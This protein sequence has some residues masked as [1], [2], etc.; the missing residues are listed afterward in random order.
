MQLFGRRE[1]FT[2][3]E[4]ITPYNVLEV[5]EKTIP[6]HNKNRKQIQYLYNYYTG[7]QPVLYREKEIRPEINNKIVENRANEIVSFK[8][9]YLMGEPI[10]YVNRSGD[11][12]TV[13]SIKRL[14][15]FVFAEDKPTKDKELADWLH[16]CGLAYRM[17]L[18]NDRNEED[19]S[20]FKI[21]T[22]S[23]M[24]TFVVRY[25]GLGNK[26]VMGVKYVVKNNRTVV[27]SVYTDD[28]YFEIENRN[29]I[30]DIA[31]NPLGRI[32]IIEYQ[33]NT[34]RLGAFE[35]VIPLLD[36][37]NETASNRLDG[38]EQFIQA[39]LMLKGVDI[40][41]ADFK[42]LKD[43][44][45][46]KIPLDGDIK[47]LVQELDQSQVQTYVNYMYDA[48]LTICGMPNRNGGSSTS[49][50]GKAVIM[51][52]GWSSAEARAK[53]TESMFK[54][55]EKDFLRLALMI[56]DAYRDLNLKL[57]QIDI[58]FTRRNYENIVEKSQVLTTM[59]SNDKIH[60]RLAFEHC[61]MF[62]DP[63]TAYLASKEY[64]KE[65]EAETQ[66]KLDDSFETQIDDKKK[67]LT[68]DGEED[69]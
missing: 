32:P 56:S 53:D 10:Q 44:G 54:K 5:L 3:V 20:P 40:E 49:D 15:E 17:A 68:A 51:R 43:L 60:P 16:I 19:E 22:L 50:T 13:H 27:Y 59:L 24:N 48:V 36:A 28:Y 46:I 63:E 55:S 52:D 23:P 26:P 67:K 58:Q 37:I 38:I 30:V 33:A 7:K 57:S 39:L 31:E 8:T 4:I 45:G 69:V 41:A 25:N 29:K 1:I 62:I 34:A 35:V 18:P 64:E 11:D 12:N 6:V 65:R 66:K 14:N 2:D 47:Y 21:Y 61:G 9:G 42:A